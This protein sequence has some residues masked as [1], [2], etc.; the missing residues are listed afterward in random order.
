MGWISIPAAL[1]AK[2]MAA[3]FSQEMPTANGISSAFVLVCDSPIK[4][5]LRSDSLDSEDP[6]SRSQ[7]SC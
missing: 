4:A 6:C 2:V 3:H 1:L 7:A 5:S